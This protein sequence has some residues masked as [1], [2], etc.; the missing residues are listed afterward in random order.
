MSAPY[1]TQA[2]SDE[3]KEVL[4][5]MHAIL[6][7]N[8]VEGLFKLNNTDPLTA[9]YSSI[10]L[11]FSDTPSEADASDL[12]TFDQLTLARHLLIRSSVHEP[13]GGELACVRAAERKSL[14]KDTRDY[15]S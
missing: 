4:T 6:G 12:A 10:T 13:I 3:D 14:K 7:D 2:L 11:A 8:A 9:A 1:K 15:S 5:S